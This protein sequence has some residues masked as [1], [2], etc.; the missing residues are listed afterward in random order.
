LDFSGKRAFPKTEHYGDLVVEFYTDQKS[1]PPRYHYIIT[2]VGQREILNWGQEKSEAEA[3][4]SAK[5]MA[6]HFLARGDD[7]G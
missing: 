6:H 4:R 7:A 5:T 3:H 2:R 1:E